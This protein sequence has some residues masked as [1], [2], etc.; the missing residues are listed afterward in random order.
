VAEVDR[1]EKRASRVREEF[2]EED[3]V[4]VM[5]DQDRATKGHALVI[6]KG[7]QENASEL[8]HGEFAHFS[9]EFRRAELS[10]LDILKLDRSIALKTE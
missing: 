5:L 1:C 3:K 4:L 7:H 10:L 6:W 9:E 2:F 8:S